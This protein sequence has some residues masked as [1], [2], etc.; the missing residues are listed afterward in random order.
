M[1][2]L[3][4]LLTLSIASCLAATPVRYDGYEVHRITPHTK[5]QVFVLRQLENNPNLNFWTDV[6]VPGR[7]V[8]IMVPPNL[9][10]YFQNFTRQYNLEDKIW[11]E[12]VQQRIEN[13]KR[14]GVRAIGWQNWT[15]YQTL[16]EIYAWLDSLVL[17]YPDKVTPI[18]GGR[19]YQ[20]REIRGVRVSFGSGKKGVFIEGGIHS[21]EWIS[22]ATITYMLNQ[23]LTSDDAAVRSAAESRDW[24][25]FPSVNPD[26]YVYTHI[27]DRMWR[28][29]RKPYGSTCYGADPNR[30]WDY[31]W[32]EGGASTLPC[33]EIHGGSAPFSEIE[34][35]TLA[36]YI[37]SVAE[38][39]DI[40]LAFHSFSQLI[41][42]PFG[43]EGNELP[44]N[45]EELHRIANAAAES[46]FKRYGTNY[47][48]G[49][50]PEAIYTASGGSID[51]VLG[52]HRNIRIVYAY[53]LRDKGKFGF[54]LPA[55]QIVPTGEE[56]L[57]SVVR[58]IQE[59]DGGGDS[60]D[61]GSSATSLFVNF[62]VLSTIVLAHL[63]K[64]AL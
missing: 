8:D 43:H 6:S 28:R 17:A 13:E 49:N 21:R 5:A 54:I 56:T 22:P 3:L 41:L 55:D 18:V 35:K 37:S 11:I 63:I 42:I 7:N 52:K 46:L 9:K 64:L 32:M 45:N 10:Y 33:S 61:G 4:L 29:T 36:E 60:G 50:I 30:N 12:D 14:K 40:Y 62:A 25:I 59:A 44:G 27:N 23:I 51:W 2:R 1:K 48:V 19:S 16:D 26:G 24:H 53:E 38:T 47:T 15:D 20:G 34:T 31:H 39:L 57:D 58:I